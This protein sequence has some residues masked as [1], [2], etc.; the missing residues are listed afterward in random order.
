M[1]K[2]IILLLTLCSSLLANSQTFLTEFPVSNFSSYNDARMSHIPKNLVFEKVPYIYWMVKDEINRFVV[3]NEKLEPIATFKDI[4]YTEEN[5]YLVGETVTNGCC[6]F[7]YDNSIAGTF[8]I[9]QTFFNN[10]R[11]FELIYPLYDKT[12]SSIVENDWNGDGITDSKSING[13]RI[14]FKVVSDDG[15]EVFTYKVNDDEIL[16]FLEFFT[17]GDVNYLRITKVI[18]N[19]DNKERVC[20]FYR[21]DKSTS[22]IKLVK[23][24]KF[25]VNPTIADRSD[26]ITVELDDNHQVREMSV[27]N[28]AGQVVK[29]VP[30][31]PGQKHVTFSAH[32]M[33]QGL[34]IINAPEKGENNTQKIMVK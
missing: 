21:I 20:C 28:A 10:D 32:G 3:Y 16:D 26:V 30:V 31:A 12:N 1:K 33:S 18:Y 24:T 8:E 6:Y 7:N 22:S 19:N 9:N 15:N 4:S 14:G 29:R 34:N 2:T 5:N 17:L 27:I 13:K 23:E 11:N 25:K